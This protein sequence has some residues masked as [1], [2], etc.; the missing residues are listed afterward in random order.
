MGYLEKEYLSNRGSNIENKGEENISIIGNKILERI[1]NTVNNGGWFKGKKDEDIFQTIYLTK[2]KTIIP[3]HLTGNLEFDIISTYFFIHSN[4][5]K[6]IKEQIKPKKPLL[7]FIKPSQSYYLKEKDPT[8]V[9]ITT[10]KRIIWERPYY[11]PIWPSEEKMA[12]HLKSI[13][14]NIEEKLS[15]NNEKLFEALEKTI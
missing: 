8:T 1:K 14:L 2:R 10:S 7:L 6:E 3:E 15:V 5:L 12:R 9:I 11:S 4:I 13:Y